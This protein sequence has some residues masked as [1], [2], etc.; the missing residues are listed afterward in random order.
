MA[1]HERRKFIAYGLQA[2]AFICVSTAA[3]AVC[4]D[5]DDLSDSIQGMRDSLKYT[6]AA[7]DPTQACKACSFFKPA[8]QSDECAHCEVLN[9]PVRA[10][11]HCVSWTKRS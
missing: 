2:S 10:T 9:S 5:P 11:G 6:D 4:V 3:G 1:G 7:S 8:K